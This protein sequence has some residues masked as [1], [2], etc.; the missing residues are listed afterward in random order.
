MTYINQIPLPEGQSSFEAFEKLLGAFT[1]ALVLDDLPLA[2][3]RSLL[4]L[5]YIIRNE[6]GEPGGRLSVTANPALAKLDGTDIY[7]FA[8]VTRAGVSREIYP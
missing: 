1:N 5:R 2:R 3:R 8:L 4:L 6:D 7:R